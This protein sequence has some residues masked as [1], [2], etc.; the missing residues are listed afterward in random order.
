MLG[1]A[2][3]RKT[4]RPRAASRRLPGNPVG[5]PAERPVGELLDLPSGLLLEPVVM[6]AFWAAITQ[7][8]PPARLVRRVVLE[9]AGGGGPPADRRGTR[10]VPDLGQMPQL[11]PGVMPLGLETVLARVGADGGEGDGQVRAG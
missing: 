3:R 2:G 7:A 10:R 5:P 4:R 8:G 9:V 11:D 6:P 1:A